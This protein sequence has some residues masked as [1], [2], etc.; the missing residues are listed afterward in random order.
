MPYQL[1]EE[2]VA[3]LVEDRQLYHAEGAE[4]VEQMLDALTPSKKRQLLE[5]L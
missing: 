4:L 1:V 2:L 3:Y 5:V